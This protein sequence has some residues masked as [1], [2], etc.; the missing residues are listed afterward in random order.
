M[1]I[2]VS[3]EEDRRIR[4]ARLPEPPLFLEFALVLTVE[5]RVAVEEAEAEEGVRPRLPDA[6][7]NYLLLSSFVTGFLNVTSFLG[8]ICSLDAWQGC[9]ANELHFEC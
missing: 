7:V 1:H 4:R 9:M 3:A 6:S 8:V 5:E 2:T